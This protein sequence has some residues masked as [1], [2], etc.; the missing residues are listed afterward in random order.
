MALLG[1]T[2]LA[3]GAAPRAEARGRAPV[4][5]AFAL[6]LPWPLGAIDPHRVEDTTA[7]ILGE[8]LFESLYALTAAGAVVPALAE[9]DPEPSRGGLRVPLR[10]G[11]RTAHDRPLDARDAVASLA[12]AR[13]LGACGWL[14]DLP[15]P[16]TDGKGALFFATRDAD[17]LS[18]A[19]A[20]PLVAIVPGGFS[21]ERPDG[22]GPFRADRR[23]DAL[24]LTRSPRAA[25][26]PSFLDEVVV[27]P[28][29]DLAAPLRAFESGEDT[30][31]WLGSGLHEPRPG[32][33]PF[34]FGVVAW[35]LLRTGRL[36]GSWDAPGIAQRIADG[37]AHSR[38]AYLVLGRPWPSE[39]EEGWGGPPCELLVREDAPW[40]IELARA[41]AATISRPQHEVVARPTP[42]L[43]VAQRR[44]T[45]IFTLLLDVARPL[46]PTPMGTFLGLATADDAATV[47]GIATHAPRIVDPNPRTLTRTMRIGVLGEVRVQGARSP[48]VTLAATPSGGLDLGNATRARR[49]P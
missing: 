44:V 47:G 28:S 2:A 5:G 12:R 10:S 42:A 14:A 31:G 24:V 13:S 3:L 27:R 34:D 39:N 29:V 17:R 46:A 49:G 38:L 23:G 21:G 18:R 7:A 8:S 16:R 25:A 11:L 48:D 33:R 6:H 45:R 20:S 40:L 15:A 9:S 32:A 22:T 1:G 19:L 37:I 36:A 4:G 30:I 41:V 35:P 26:G 43:E